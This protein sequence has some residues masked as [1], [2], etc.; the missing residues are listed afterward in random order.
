MDTW[1]IIT[2]ILGLLL[3]GS[4]IS[5][6][7]IYFFGR[8]QTNQKSQAETTKIYAEA[9]KAEAEARST[10]A[11]TIEQMQTTIRNLSGRLDELYTLRDEDQKRIDDLEREIRELKQERIET[12]VEV[13]RLNKKVTTLLNGINRLIKQ[14]RDHNIEP[15]W[16][17][18]DE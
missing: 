10:D 14:L 2:V 7:I 18:D 4:G 11:N 8:K 9:Q 15:T 17:P 16:L 5:G 12:D 3:G 1:Q 6:L 13:G